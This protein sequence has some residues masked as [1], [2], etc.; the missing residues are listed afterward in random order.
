MRAGKPW[1]PATSIDAMLRLASAR[2]TPMWMQPEGAA[3][4]TTSVMLSSG[5][6]IPK[7][8]LARGPPDG[9][10]TPRRHGGAGPPHT[11]E[12]TASRHTALG[13]GGGTARAGPSTRASAHTTCTTPSPV[14]AGRGHG[15]MAQM[16]RMGVLGMGS[17]GGGC[18]RR[19]GPPRA[20]SVS[21]PRSR[22]GRRSPG[23]PA[24]P[25]PPR[26]RPRRC[27]PK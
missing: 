22:A 4:A 19:T 25:P 20:R 10:S 1:A 12:P 18:A 16:C 5:F 7:C 2:T 9:E 17:G 27:S 23:R 11:P 21:G 24:S 3:A 26:S 14:L 8:P 13:R 6:F 15:A